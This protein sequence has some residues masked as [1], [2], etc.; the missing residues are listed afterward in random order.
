MCVLRRYGAFQWEV[1]FL[2]LFSLRLASLLSS[3][4]SILD[5]YIVKSEKNRPKEYISLVCLRSISM[6][7]HSDVRSS[8]RP[9]DSTHDKDVFLPCAPHLRTSTYMHRRSS[10]WIMFANQWQTFPPFPRT[11]DRLQFS[12][13]RLTCTFDFIDDFI[14]ETLFSD[15]LLS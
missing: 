10:S 2:T 12:Y 6:S 5:L 3:K 14:N 8:A 11:S 4:W 9:H 13:N 1:F 15:L 7:S